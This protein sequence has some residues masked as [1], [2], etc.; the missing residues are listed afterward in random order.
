LLLPVI[1][2]TNWGFSQ[3][4]ST[5]VLP[6]SGNVGIGVLNPQSLLQVGGS[7]RIDSSLVVKDSLVIYKSAFVKGDLE[8]NENAS[9][10]SDALVQEELVVKGNTTLYGDLNLKALAGL[11]STDNVLLVDSTGKVTNGGSLK[12]LIYA[13]PI[14]AQIQCPTDL[15]GNTIYTAPSWQASANPQRMFLVSS[16]CSPN[17]MLGVGVKPEAKFHV[18]LEPGSEFLPLIID[19][20]VGN[21]PAVPTYKL[22]Q[23]NPDGTL[24]ARQVE[25]NLDSWPDYVFEA[26]YR[27]MSL[28]ELGAYIAENNHL[29][30]VPGVAEMKENGLNVAQNSIMLMEKIEELTLYILQINEQI[31]AQ[32]EIS[33]QQ[34]EIIRLQQQ[35]IEQLQQQVNKAP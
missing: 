31:K 5:N 10:Q 20:Q 26:G 18:R 13:E 25:V 6:A 7:A 24:F 23:L 12:S 30:H 16:N 2:A 15:N 21:N 11:S 28:E 22:M 32:K 9:F 33:E 29:P 35:L 27:L 3:E 17:P 1:T 8:V 34:Q 19:K 14:S 4:D